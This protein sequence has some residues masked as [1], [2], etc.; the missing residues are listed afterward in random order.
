MVF[1]TSDLDFSLSA[2]DL[3]LI[4]KAG[5]ASNFPDVVLEAVAQTRNIATPHS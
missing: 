1:P 3:S 4:L 2:K 5:T